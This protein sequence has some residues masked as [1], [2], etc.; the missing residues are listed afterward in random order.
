M[1]RSSVAIFARW[2]ATAMVRSTLVIF[3]RSACSGD[4][5]EKNVCGLGQ[6][7]KSHIT[8]HSNSAEALQHLVGRC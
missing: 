5:L 3:E 4:A 2:K 6:L 8:A 7:M 1:T